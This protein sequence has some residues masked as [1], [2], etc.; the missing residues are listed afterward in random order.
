MVNN[1]THDATNEIPKKI[2]TMRNF[3]DI[4]TE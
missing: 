3:A 2:V 4:Q 1:V